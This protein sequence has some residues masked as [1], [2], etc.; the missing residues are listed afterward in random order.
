MRVNTESIQASRTTSHSDILPL[1]LVHNYSLRTAN[2]YLRWLYR[3]PLR[4]FPN[5][6]GC[7]SDRH[8]DL[9]VVKLLKRSCINFSIETRCHQRSGSHT[10]L[11][12]TERPIQLLHMHSNLR[13]NGVM[14]LETFGHTSYHCASLFH[15]SSW[16]GNG[17][18]TSR[19]LTFT[20]WP[21][22]GRG[23]VAALCL[24]ALPT[25]IDVYLTKSAQY[26]SFLIM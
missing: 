13:S 9:K 15:G 21:A 19:I 14:T 1:N 24:V 2:I 4:N 6:R 3:E 16:S 8:S 26:A 18:Q 11:G 22:Y 17:E 5:Y 20:P 10:S 7:Y 25:S 23:H 12:A